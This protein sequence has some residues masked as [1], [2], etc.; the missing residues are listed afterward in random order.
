MNKN[1]GFSFICISCHSC[2]W[3]VFSHLLCTKGHPS[4]FSLSQTKKKWDIH[5]DLQWNVIQ[6]Q[7]ELRIREFP[8]QKTLD[9]RDVFLT[10]QF[11]LIIISWVKPKLWYITWQPQLIMSKIQINPQHTYT[12]IWWLTIF[13]SAMW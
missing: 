5:R 1:F 10:S 4:G 8:T 2:Q 3:I 13:V 9:L 12:Y 11:Q 6:L 7:F